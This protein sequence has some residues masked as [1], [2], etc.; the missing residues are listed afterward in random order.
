MN[1][2]RRLGRFRIKRT[3]L[4]QLDE[5]LRLALTSCTVLDSS[6]NVVG[7]YFEYTAVS[8]FFSEVEEESTPRLYNLRI[9]NNGFSWE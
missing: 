7:D 5:G 8:Y 2:T 1:D 3:D 9:F 4:M 6:Y